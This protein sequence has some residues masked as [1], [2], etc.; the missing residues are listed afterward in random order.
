[1]SNR[2][3]WSRARWRTSVVSDGGGCVEVARVGVTIGV[4]DTKAHGTG[5]VL[6]FTLHEWSCFVAGVRSGEFDLDQLER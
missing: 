3:D 2:V 1:M 5:S 4:R 6:E